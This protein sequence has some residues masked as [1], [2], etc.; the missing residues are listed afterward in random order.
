MF[1]LYKFIFE[2]IDGMGRAFA[3]GQNAEDAK[4]EV[5]KELTE[6]LK[7][8][9]SH[10]DIFKFIGTIDLVNYKNIDTGCIYTNQTI[11]NLMIGNH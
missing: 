1:K 4:W 5:E 10:K 8:Y 11:P 9:L 3:I 2:G 7:N 6:R